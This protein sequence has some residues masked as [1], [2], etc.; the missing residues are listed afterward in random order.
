MPNIERRTLNWGCVGRLLNIGRS[1]FG[2][3]CS[4]FFHAVSFHGKAAVSCHF[5]AV[6]VACRLKFGVKASW[7][8]S[9]LGQTIQ[10]H[11][12][13]LSINELH[14]FITKRSQ[15]KSS[16]PHPQCSTTPIPHLPI[17]HCVH[18]A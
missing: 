2:V 3:G 12:N 6:W 10:K 18:F 17:P 9:R 16:H 13:K 7:K 15:A 4:E 11:S 5:V 8:K 1:E 14:H